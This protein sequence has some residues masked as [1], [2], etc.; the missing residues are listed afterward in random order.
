MSLSPFGTVDKEASS[1]LKGSVSPHWSPELRALEEGAFVFRLNIYIF[2]FPLL[3]I[4][5][6]SLFFFLNSNLQE[7]I[8]FVMLGRKRV[9][10]LHE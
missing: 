10:T 6:L 1:P 5:S 2:N 8:Q 7:Q 4:L 9:F 3:L